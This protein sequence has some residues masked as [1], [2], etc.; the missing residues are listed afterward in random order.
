MRYLARKGHSSIF[1]KNQIVIFG[2]E[3]KYNS[4]HKYRESCNDVRWYD[5]DTFE[6][7]FKKKRK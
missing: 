5:V 1:Y 4:I 7:K 3:K 6:W 2:G